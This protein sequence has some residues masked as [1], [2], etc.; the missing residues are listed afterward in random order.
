MIF[1]K[2]CSS[3]IDDGITICPI[4][5]A[6]AITGEIATKKEMPKFKPAP[7]T[8]SAAPLYS[9]PAS[10]PVSPGYPP[11]TSRP[12]SPGYPPPA[13]RPVSPGYP[14][15]ASR[16][17]SPGYPPP[18]SRPVSPGYPSSTSRPVSP[19]YPP[20]TSRPATRTDDFVNSKYNADQP[21]ET[22]PESE[23]FIKSTC[24][25]TNIILSIL[26]VIT[27]GIG[28]CFVYLRV[29]SA[30]E[31]SA[32]APKAKELVEEYVHSLNIGDINTLGNITVI[33]A[34]SDEQLEE[35]YGATYDE[36]GDE[37]Y[38]MF[39]KF[40][41]YEVSIDDVFVTDMGDS[42]IKEINSNA[43]SGIKADKGLN[44]SCTM[45]LDRNGTTDSRKRTLSAVQI[46]GKWYLY[47][48]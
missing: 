38:V 26:I 44:I 11:S 1:C 12:V 22:S 4:C 25:V 43:P 2:N 3:R 47:N 21:P 14:P 36:I 41:D 10:R 5:G 40:E 13:S 37:L 39:S 35:F 15:S 42:Q 33:S 29:W 31:E 45:K 28:G 7:P 34:L 17:V 27:L 20:S 9:P 32:S 8:R 6:N 30:P 48:L 19:G 23:Q 16:P 46:D 24:R 18:T